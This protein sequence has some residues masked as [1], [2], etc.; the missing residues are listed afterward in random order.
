MNISELISKELISLDLQADTKAELINEMV[1]LLDQNGRL[2]DKDAFEKAVLEREKTYSTGIGMGIAIPHGKSAGVKKASIAF[3]RKNKGID[4]DSLD[5][6]PAKM[7]FLIAV[8]EASN[9][10]HLKILSKLSRSLMHEQTR[11]ALMEANEAQD[12][13]NILLEEIK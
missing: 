3:G 13:I 4:F 9:D 8:P 2:S 7:F 10:V 6:K 1:E 5:G 11:K 12:I